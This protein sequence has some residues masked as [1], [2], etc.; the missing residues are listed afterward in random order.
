MPVDIF[1]LSADIPLASDGSY[2]TPA[3]TNGGEEVVREMSEETAVNPIS[4]SPK[5]EYAGENEVA[6]PVPP[7]SISPVRGQHSICAR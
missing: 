4:S 5:L 3:H 7:P 6:V 2:H 1:D